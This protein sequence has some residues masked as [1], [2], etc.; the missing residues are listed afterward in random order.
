MM[1]ETTPEYRPA[2]LLGA[3]NEEILTGL[4]FSAEDIAKMKEGGVI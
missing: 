2:P 1:S 4:G 3:H